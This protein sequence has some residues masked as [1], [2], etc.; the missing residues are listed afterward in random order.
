[1]LYYGTLFCARN[2]P[3]SQIETRANWQ[4]I[5]DHYPPLVYSGR[6]GTL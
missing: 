1:M 5:K 4:L 3:D 6:A 2:V